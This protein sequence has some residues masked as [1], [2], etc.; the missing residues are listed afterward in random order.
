MVCVGFDIPYSLSEASLSGS[1]DG[2]TCLLNQSVQSSGISS[3]AWPSPGPPVSLSSFHLQYNDTKSEYMLSR[4]S[5]I[6]VR[7]S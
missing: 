5:T 2:M 1:D 4:N 3:S 7:V 6:T